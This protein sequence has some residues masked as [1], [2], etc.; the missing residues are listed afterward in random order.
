MRFLSAVPIV[1][2]ALLAAWCDST[3]QEGEQVPQGVEEGVGNS[4]SCQAERVAGPDASPVREYSVPPGI[5]DAPRAR[6]MVERL[7]PPALRQAGV[8]GTT[9]LH[10]LIDTA[11]AVPEARVATSSGHAE[12]DSAAVEAA[13]SFRFT[14]AYSGRDPACIWMTLPV[15]FDPGS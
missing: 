7:Y 15:R 6:A 14:P 1:C 9:M 3:R 2:S 5:A 13:R 8:G 4:T 12:L 10:F 11:G